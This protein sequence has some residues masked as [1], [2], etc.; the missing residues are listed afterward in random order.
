MHPLG[1]GLHKAA[2]GFNR[3]DMPQYGLVYTPPHKRNAF[4]V[5]KFKG[6]IDDHRSLALLMTAPR[7][8]G[9]H[10]MYVGILTIPMFSNR[11][12]RVN[13]R[14]NRNYPST[15]KFRNLCHRAPLGPQWKLNQAH[16]ALR[17][18]VFYNDS[19]RHD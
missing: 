16:G 15:E 2:R 7:P 18:E 17:N 5:Q 8:S 6:G 10:R 14:R 19:N 13:S 11:H 12:R 9:R 3:I 4:A 1:A